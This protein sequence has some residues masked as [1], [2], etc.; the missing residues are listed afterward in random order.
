MPDLAASLRLSIEVNEEEAERLLLC[1]RQQTLAA[2]QSLWH[3]GDHP[4]WLVQVCSGL[5]RA[6]ITTDEGREYIKEFYW[7]RD[8]FLDF[9]H[10][11][12]G[13]PARYDV[14][15]IEPCLLRLFPLSRLL[16]DPLWPRWYKSLL[17]RQLRVKE[18][19]E[20]LLLTAD[21][22]TRYCHFLEHYPQLDIR[23]KDNQIAAYLGITP[24]SL[25]R[26][27]RRLKT[28]NQS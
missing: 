19:K 10:L 16:Q 8:E 14:E 7:E 17:E 23:L 2:R 25:S 18:E 6:R 5:L 1:S 3:A 21:P 22:Q 24:I 28:L 15:A 20:W 27:R 11:L 9:H 13:T 12:T 26:I 4:A